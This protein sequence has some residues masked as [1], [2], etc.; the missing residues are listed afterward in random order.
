MLELKREAAG[1]AEKMALLMR[2]KAELQT[3]ARPSS[4]ELQTRFQACERR[5]GSMWWGTGSNAGS[6]AGDR[7]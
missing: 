4:N 1:Q 7:C 2:D 5:R 3:Q 6:D